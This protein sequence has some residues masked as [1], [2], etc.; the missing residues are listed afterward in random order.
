MPDNA[1]T[2]THDAIKDDK[3]TSAA[4][5]GCHAAFAA[6]L[7]QIDRQ[8]SVQQAG[9]CSNLFT[10]EAEQ[11][12]ALK[13]VP[14]VAIGIAH[15]EVEAVRLTPAGIAERHETPK[16]ETLTS[17]NPARISEGLEAEAHLGLIL[18]F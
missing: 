17:Q 1:Y 5:I 16:N 15:S 11:P 8:K 3:I 4:T 13:L 9:N 6:E 18:Q 10:K 14:F 2:T 12:E 7:D